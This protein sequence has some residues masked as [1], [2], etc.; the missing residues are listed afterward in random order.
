VEFTCDS[1]AYSSGVVLEDGTGVS[2]KIKSTSGF[3]L[4]TF[5][6]NVPFIL[7]PL[8]NGK[9]DKNDRGRKY[10]FNWGGQRKFE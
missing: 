5:C 9:R 4:C 7:L 1:G 6:T 10:A 2:K 8:I 3:K